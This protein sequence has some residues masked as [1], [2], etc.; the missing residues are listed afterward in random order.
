ML[1]REVGHVNTTVYSNI[2]RVILPNRDTYSKFIKTV[3]MKSY[4]ERLSIDDNGD[5]LKTLFLELFLDAIEKWNNRSKVGWFLDFVRL[6]I[7][8]HRS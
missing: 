4:L 7:V 6:N 3:V 2:D 8:A 5:K 1:L